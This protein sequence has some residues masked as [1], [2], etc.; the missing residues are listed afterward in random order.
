MIPSR[1]SQRANFA[2]Q[3]SAM[4]ECTSDKS[5]SLTIDQVSMM[6]ETVGIMPAME[7]A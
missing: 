3:E 6:R 7:Q 5:G 1:L 4:E 2:F